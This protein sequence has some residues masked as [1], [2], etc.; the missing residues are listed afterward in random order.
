MR[1]M[2]PA[3]HNRVDIPYPWNQAVRPMVKMRAAAAAIMGHGLGSTKWN[4]WPM[5]GVCGVL[6]F[7]VGVMVVRGKY[8]LEGL[9]PTA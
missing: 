9:Q 4:G 3:P 5:E 7:I 8:P 1:A 6:F 2:R